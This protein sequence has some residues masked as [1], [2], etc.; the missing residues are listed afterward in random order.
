MTPQ[1][2]QHLKEIGDK[3]EPYMDEVLD[4]F[5]AY[6]QQNPD[7][8]KIL[9]NSEIIPLKNKQKA[10]WL[11]ALRQGLDTDY[12]KR[13]RHIG[14]AHERIGL[15]PAFYM[16]G[17]GYIAEKIFD[18]EKSGRATTFG[19]SKAT[20]VLTQ[21]DLKVFV[22]FLMYDMAMSIMIY[23]EK[24]T[25][26]IE[27][28]LEISNE[29]INKLN[30]DI[31]H[32]ASSMA[33]MSST[34]QEISQQA[35]QAQ[36]QA[37]GAK[38]QMTNLNGGMASLKTASETIGDV[39]KIILEI[40]ERTN[41]LSLNAAIEAARAGEHGKGFAVVADEV[42]KLASRTN[43][44]IDEINEQVKAIQSSVEKA[45]GQ[46]TAVSGSVTEIEDVNSSITAAVTEQ[47]ATTDEMQRF[48]EDLLSDANAT[49]EKIA[50]HSTSAFK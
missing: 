46:A 24:K 13:V 31:E 29:F 8:A 32:T 12:N 7:L 5:Y 16:G 27:H 35:N 10:H 19:R 28:V 3:I 30:A 45:T 38:E 18:L 44:S 48:I 47:S 37:S 34:I 26:S 9:G 43:D 40:S 2:T 15:N 25:E 23:Q 39:L 14:N 36:D 6:I 42:K 1:T 20:S 22:R 33:E 4:A 50:Q 41:L 17:Y 11:E 49:K 21:D